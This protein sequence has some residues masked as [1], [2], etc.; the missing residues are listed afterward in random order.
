VTRYSDLKPAQFGIYATADP[1]ANMF[2]AAAWEYI[3]SGPVAGKTYKEDASARH[4]QVCH[5]RAPALHGSLVSTT[6]YALFPSL[7]ASAVAAI[8]GHGVVA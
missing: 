2:V 4:A 8:A 6:F 1:Q 7:S 3:A 5:P